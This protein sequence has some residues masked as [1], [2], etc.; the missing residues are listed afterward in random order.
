[1]RTSWRFGIKLFGLATLALLLGGAGRAVAMPIVYTD[2]ATASGTLGSTPFTNAL[3]TVTFTGDTNT[4]TGG[5]P[6]F[7]N[8]VGV[9]QVTV[10][11][12][13]TATFTNP[14]ETFDNQ[15]QQFAG[16]ADISG[17]PVSVL[18]TQNAAFATYDLKSF[19]GPFT[20]PVFFNAGHTFPTTA[21]GFTLQS[22]LNN[23]S[24]FTATAPAAAVPE[25][26]SL[27]LFGVGALGL[28]GWRLWRPRITM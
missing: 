21:G 27:A 20:G 16:I 4:V 2:Q 24:T 25:P 11:G 28:A 1:M 5:V 26:T 12:I 7:T 18:D 10:A 15:T 17:S 8:T 23:T 6:F 22:V 3:V 19:I 14:M 9:A 13:G